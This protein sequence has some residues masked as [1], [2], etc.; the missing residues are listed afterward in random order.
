MNG[1]GFEILAP[2][3]VQQLSKVT[4]PASRVNGCDTLMYSAEQGLIFI[5][6]IYVCG[7]VLFIYLFLFVWLFVLVFVCLLF[8]LVCV[9]FFCADP[10]MS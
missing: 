7:G 10:L 1:V 5:L 3:L 9:F 4:P 8:F 2:T 6:F